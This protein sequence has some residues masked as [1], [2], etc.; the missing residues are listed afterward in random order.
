[1]ERSNE[2]NLRMSRR[3]RGR[4]RNHEPNMSVKSGT[5]QIHLSIPRSM[6]PGNIS[7]K[8]ANSRQRPMSPFERRP[9]SPHVQQPRSPIEHAQRP[10][11]PFENQSASPSPRA[12]P[13]KS[14]MF[15]V[16][17]PMENLTPRSG[18]N[19]QGITIIPDPG[20]LFSS[21]REIQNGH[22]LTPRSNTNGNTSFKVPPPLDLSAIVLPKSPNGVVKKQYEARSPTISQNFYRVGSRSAKDTV[23]RSKSFTARH[24]IKK[25]ERNSSNTLPRSTSNYNFTS[26][27]TFPRS[28]SPPLSSPVSSPRTPVN[29]SPRP[30]SHY[31]TV[32]PGGVLDDSVTSRSVLD[33]SV[34]SQS[35]FRGNMYETYRDLCRQNDMLFKD[36]DF[37]AM[38]ESLFRQGKSP[39]GQIQWKRPGQL[40]KKPRFISNDVMDCKIRSGKLGSNWLIGCF[41]CLTGA[42]SLLKYC[43]PEGQEFGDKYAG[44]FRFRFW[45]FGQ[46]TEIVID[47]RLPT[48]NGELLYSRSNDPAEFWPSLFEKAYAK[49]QGCYEVFLGGVLGWS[50]QDITGGVTMA[51]NIQDDP[52]F[53]QKVVDIGLSRASLIGASIQGTTNGKAKTIPTG[54]VAGHVYNVTGYAELPAISETKVLIRLRDCSGMSNWQGAWSEGS[55]HWGQ[56]TYDVR[57]QVRKRKMEDGEFWMSFGDFIQIFTLLE[58]C[59]LTP[60]SWKLEPKIQYRKAWRSTQAVRQ[61]RIGFNA[62]GP[63]TSPLVFSNCQFL[64]ELEKPSCVMLSVLQKYRSSVNRVLLPVGCL[65]YNVARSFDTRLGYSEFNQ[66]KLMFSTGLH[67]KRENTGLY[68][69]PAGYYLV[70]PVTG[71]QEME[72]KFLLRIFTEGDSSIRELDEPDNVIPY[73]YDRKLD[74]TSLFS[75]RRKFLYAINQDDEVDAKGLQGILEYK[76]SELRNL[77]CCSSGN[78][79]GFTFKPLR[80]SLETCKSAVA[81]ADRDLNG[82]LNYDEFNHLLHLLMHW[83]EIY[84]KMVNGNGDMETYSLRNAL[85]MAGF[86]VSNKTLEALV[87]RFANKGTITL[88]SYVNALVKLSVA[89]QR[90]ENLPKETSKDQ[91]AFL[92]E[93]LRTAIYS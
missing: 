76:Q 6:L 2:Y 86:T 74:T 11:S 33:T 27:G 90:R 75:F 41:T 91:S 34:T 21:P 47:D 24:F 31:A 53:V 25:S 22:V 92:Q 23:N 4:R 42:P 19:G 83:Q 52:K 28:M 56:L 30:K 20:E 68:I 58:S 1:M 65:V 73:Q 66:L 59:F 38:D 60:E 43:I 48:L 93:L 16:S 67:Q 17:L 71:S 84:H 39:V 69:L 45:R 40:C 62:G 10:T 14:S 13:T 87:I 36:P 79:D 37:P 44:I 81:I 29:E 9:L 85:K 8:A 51:T 7:I 32:T 46:W 50:L 55:K 64:M 72:G 26:N 57:A 63:H 5:Y 82:R 88:E 77:W 61:W 89:H 15:A 18:Q 35:S 3:S 54:L 78:E 49:L 70:L 12:L 80:L